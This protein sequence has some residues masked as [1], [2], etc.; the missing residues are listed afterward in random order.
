VTVTTTSE[1]QIIAA[2][3]AGVFNDITSLTITNRSTANVIRVVIASSSGSGSSGYNFTLAERGGVTV[4]FSPPL[5]Q[6]T[7][8]SAWV[9]TCVVGASTFDV[10]VNYV[11]NV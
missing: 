6:T 3:A 5:K 11:S 8:A 1:T 10:V 4:A 7:A 9:A 2:G